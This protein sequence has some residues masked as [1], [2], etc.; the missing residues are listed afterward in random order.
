M[1][2]YLKKFLLNEL[3]VFVVGGSGLIG[4]EICDAV[5]CAGANTI[6]LD[7]IKIPNKK[8]KNSSTLIWR[9]FDCS[10]LNNLE[11]Q[12]L[13]II[14]EFGVPDILINCSYP[15]TRDWGKNSFKTISLKSFRKNIDIHLNSYAWLAKLTAEEMVKNHKKGNIIQF[16]SIYGL[17]GQDLSV[18]KNTE[19]HE[20]MS[21]ATIKGG[22]HN[23]TRQMASYYGQFNIR[24]NTICPGGL[25]GHVAGKSKTQNPHFVKQYIEKTPLK[26]MG[27]AD[28]IAST[29]LFLASEA[30]SYITGATIVVDG[31]WSII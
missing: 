31:G 17:I 25:S 11:K 5:T 8:T 20:N 15:R 10:N 12:L 2:D 7:K 1:H 14:K 29:A 18:Y 24:V 16:G 9:K 4:R 6:V 22:I 28:E 3:S 19:M 27:R 21:Y 26:R 23:L 30:S 13:Y